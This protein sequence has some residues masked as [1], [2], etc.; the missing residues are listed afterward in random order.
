MAEDISLQDLMKGI[1]IEGETRKRE[2]YFSSQDFTKINYV[3]RNNSKFKKNLKANNL[4][5][6]KKTSFGTNSGKKNANC[7][8][9]G[10]KCDFIR[11]RGSRKM[12]TPN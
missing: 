6:F 11:D 10:K 4:G 2:K 3:E 12:R 8:H 9:C 7:H 1:Q 5:K